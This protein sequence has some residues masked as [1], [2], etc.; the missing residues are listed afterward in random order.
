MFGIVIIM[1]QTTVMSYLMSVTPPQLRSTVYGLYFGLYLE[2]MSLMQPVIGY[3]MDKFGILNVFNI[4]ALLSVTL[5]LLA[6]FLLISKSRK[7]TI[8]N[9]PNAKH[10]WHEQ[11]E[12]TIFHQCSFKFFRTT[13]LVAAAGF[14]P[15]DG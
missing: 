7:Y 9:Y 13:T 15:L 1:R 4:I 2:G 14:E 3:F 11:R 10:D 5:S 12:S 6:L 8:P